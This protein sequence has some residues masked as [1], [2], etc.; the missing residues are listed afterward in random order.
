MIPLSIS[1]AIVSTIAKAKARNVLKHPARV[2]CFI[3]FSYTKAA[4]ASGGAGSGGTRG[5]GARMAKAADANM[6]LPELM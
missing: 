2:A 6:T 1:K 4:S 3:L 5:A